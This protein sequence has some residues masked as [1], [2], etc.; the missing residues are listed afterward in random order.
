MQTYIFEN[1]IDRIS[2][3]EVEKKNSSLLRRR[4]SQQILSPREIDNA[5]LKIK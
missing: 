4:R 2:N 1:M 3:C 5:C